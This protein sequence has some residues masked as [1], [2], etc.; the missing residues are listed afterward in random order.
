MRLLLTVTD[1]EEIPVAL[2]SGADLVDV[3]DPGRGSL[4]PPSLPALRR[5]A[6][7]LGGRAPLGVGLGDGPHRPETL[8]ARVRGARR[9]GAVYLKVGLVSRGPGAERDAD[10]APER[11]SGAPP[12]E[13]RTAIEAARR[14]LAATGGGELVAVTFAD[15]PAE[16][17]PSPEELVDVAA[18]AGADVAMLDTLGKEGGSLLRLLGRRRIRWWSREVRS[19]GLL[20]AVAGGLDAGAV[21]R[22]AGTGVDVVGIRGGACEGGRGGRLDPGR[23]R[24]IRRAVHRAAARPS[25]RPSAPHRVS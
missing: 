15:A 16:I 13:A 2:A 22:L 7:R 19:Q 18:T 9:A 20:A 10:P 12:A 3:K 21:G 11:S 23:C 17:A 14:S 4:G 24:S 8:A 1:A 25:A 6:A 5:V